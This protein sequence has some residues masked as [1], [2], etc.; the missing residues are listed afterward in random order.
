MWAEDGWAD[1]FWELL[2]AS[3]SPSLCCRACP[4][5]L[6]DADRW[7]EAVEVALQETTKVVEHLVET[8]WTHKCRIA[9]VLLVLAFWC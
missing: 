7:A 8:W 9:S 3:V 5:V 6:D 2:E 4:D 1:A